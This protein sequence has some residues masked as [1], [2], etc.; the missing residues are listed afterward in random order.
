M[1]KTFYFA[2]A[3]FLVRNLLCK[4]LKFYNPNHPNP[5]TIFL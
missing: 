5:K 1:V 4:F 3:T 2:N